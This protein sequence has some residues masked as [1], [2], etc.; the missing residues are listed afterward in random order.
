MDTHAGAFTLVVRTSEHT[1]THG[2]PNAHA[3]TPCTHACN[4]CRPYDS[5][6]MHKHRWRDGYRHA[7]TDAFTWTYTRSLA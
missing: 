3:T 5:I 7:L 4:A 6:V 1:T 2:N